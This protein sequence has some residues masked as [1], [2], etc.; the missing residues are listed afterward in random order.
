MLIKN[1]IHIMYSF[2][3]KLKIKNESPLL[4]KKLVAYLLFY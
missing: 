1:I 2:F 3:M 4:K